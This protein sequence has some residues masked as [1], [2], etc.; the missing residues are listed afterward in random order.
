MLVPR[1]RW[2][3]LVATVLAVAGCSGGAASQPPPAPAADFERIEH[4]SGA[5][6]GV[7]AVDTATGEE[8]A[9][10]AGERFGYASAHKAFSSAAVLRQNAVDGLNRR[11]TYGRGDLVEHSP[12]TEKHVAGGMKL[13]EVIEAAVHDSDNTAAN[14]LFREIGGPAGLT[15]MMRSLGDATTHA[16]RVETDLNHFAPGDV[17]D[18][19]TPRAFGRSLRAVAVDHAL[20]PEERA[21]LDDVLRT[22]TSGATLVRAAAPPGWQVGDKTGGTTDHG[23]RN[24]IAVLWPPQRA[25]IVLAVL[26]DKPAEH[27]AYDDAVVARA[28]GAALAAL[29]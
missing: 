26:T 1:F 22:N 7:Y 2:S 11:V 21:F 6:V 10:R 4:D 20:P 19:T 28:A 25:P 27:A 15:A 9:H 5:R 12:V 29:R 16:D 13:R 24:D 18:T 8:V 14:L 17:R 23:I 3:V